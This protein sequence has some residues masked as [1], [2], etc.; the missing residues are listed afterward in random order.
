[1]SDLVTIVQTPLVIGL[2]E[3]A[4]IDRV[5]AALRIVS[6]FSGLAQENMTQLAG[7]R[8]LE[9]GRRIER[10]ILTCNCI[11][12]FA[13]GKSSDGKLDV[14]L[15]LAD[16]QITYRQRYVMI[17]ALAPVIDLTLLDPNNPRSVAFQ[18]D[19]IEEH[20]IALPRH[21]TAGTLS[22]VQQVAASIA[23]R[24]RTAQA[25]GI[26]RDLVVELEQMLMKL[27]EAIASSYL[28]YNERSEAVWDTLA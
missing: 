2:S 8:F 24:L 25:S 4:M 21:Q 6:S 28:T 10:A 18:L 20:L 22:P 12:R 26:T 17:A 14:M 7:W 27:S 9:L 1:M 3:T 23:T 5:E 19:R 11:R 16:S 15:E 13:T